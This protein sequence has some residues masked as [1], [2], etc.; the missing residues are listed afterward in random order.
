MTDNYYT[1]KKI[2]DIIKYYHI[3]MNNINTLAAEEMKSIGVS[4]Y[5]IES[6]LPKGNGFS[7]VV[8]NEAM[9]Q[10]ENTKFFADMITDM[11]YLQDRW[12]RITDEKEAA[13]L[14][15]RLDGYRITDIA[16]IMGMERTGVYRT[17]ERIA[18]RI[19]S[20][21]QVSATDSTNYVQENK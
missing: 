11:K 16:E 15:L 6:S 1:V 7:S 4:Q 14:K 8:E 17:L 2:M 9:R 10:I 5:G 3:N 20:Y 12:H 18:C 21:P 13:I 19:K